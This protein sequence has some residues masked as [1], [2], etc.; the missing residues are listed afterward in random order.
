[1][2]LCT[3]S[4]PKQIVKKAITKMSEL[5]KPYRTY[6]P[7][8]GSVNSIN[9]EMERGRRNTRKK[10]AEAGRVAP[11]PNHPT[12]Q[13]GPREEGDVDT[14]ADEAWL[15][16]T[17][18]EK[19]DPWEPSISEQEAKAT[20]AVAVEAAQTSEMPTPQDVE[21]RTPAAV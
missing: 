12:M 19:I 15:R 18:K 6:H 11:S 3:Y 9:D 20:G 16:F 1:M 14:L 13:G 5:E 10:L 21:P 2:L 4:K 8:D 17:G 7:I